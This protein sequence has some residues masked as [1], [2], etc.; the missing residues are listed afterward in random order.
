MHFEIPIWLY[1]MQDRSKGKAG[2]VISSSDFWSTLNLKV[3]SVS[4][5][6]LC[7]VVLR[8]IHINFGS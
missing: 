7:V 6:S 5:R 4:S 8:E 3:G 1:A 2:E